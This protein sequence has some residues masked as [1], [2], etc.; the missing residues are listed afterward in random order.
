MSLIAL[1]NRTKFKED[2]FIKDWTPEMEN[3]FFERAQQGESTPL[4]QA[5][6]IN[7]RTAL[8]YLLGLPHRPP[9]TIESYIYRN[10]PLLWSIANCHIAASLILLDSQ[11]VP[12]ENEMRAQVN[13][14]CARGNTPLIL[15]LAKGWYHKRDE[16]R[17]YQDVESQ[18]IV[19]ERLLNLGANVHAKNAHGCTALH[20]ACLHRAKPAIEQ[21]L[22]H[23]ANLFEVNNE[24]KTAYEFLFYSK[25][26]A[27]KELA[28]VTVAN[29]AK[30]KNWDTN[31]AEGKQFEIFRSKLAPTR[32]E[33]EIS[34]Y[35]S[36]CYGFFA[37]QNCS[38]EIT[39]ISAVLAGIV[40][41]VIAGLSGGGL[42]FI[43]LGAATGIGLGL[44][45][46]GI[47]T[48]CTDFVVEPDGVPAI[49]V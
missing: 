20:Y 8:I 35:K 10:T 9:L 46:Y 28:K 23:N 30:D 4:H 2:D 5:A 34:S 36:N 37:S 3:L 47:Y 41:A 29:T 27:K 39:L 21:L 40:G 12:D 26:Q 43:L 48:A 16:D 18:S 38:P 14:P 15:S 25:E 6:M 42:V 7:H 22:N 33:K 44:I 24:G 19:A 13:K 1:I 11:Y 31:F 32:V 49:V 45:G 17:L